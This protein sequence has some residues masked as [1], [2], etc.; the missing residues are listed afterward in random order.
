MSEAERTNLFRRNR[1]AFRLHHPKIWAELERIEKPVSRA[2]IENDLVVN[3][4]LGEIRLYPDPAPAWTVRQLDDYFANPDR[5]VFENPFHCNLS[6]VSVEV[7]RDIGDYL[8]EH[9]RSKPASFPVV[10]VG[11]AFI[12]GVG[13][14]LHVADL[15]RRKVARNLILIEP[16]PEF[17]LHSM[18]AVDWSRIFTAAR[19][20]GMAIDFLLGKDPGATI[21]GI[22]VLFSRRGTTFL[23]GSYAYRH[24]HSWV[25]Q[26]ARAQLNE[27]IKVFYFSS[28]FFEDEILMMQNTYG[29]LR[30]RAFHVVD[31]RPRIARR[32]PAFVIGSGSSLDRDLPYIKKW[33]DRA[34]VCS[35]GTSL[36]ILLKNGI[37]PD[38]H[39]ENENTLPLVK[40]L[41]NFRETYGLDGIRLVCTTTLRPEAS[42]LFDR[43]WF[44]YRAPLSSSVVLSGGIEPLPNADPLVSNAGCAAL[45]YLGFQDIYLFGVDC[46]RHFEGEHHSR[47]AVYYQ[48]GYDINPHNRPDAGFE[49]VVPGNFGGKVVTSW[50][51]DLSRRSITAL[52]K[53]RDVSVTNCSDGARIEGTRPKVA[54][55]LNFTYPPNEQEAVLTDIEKSLPFFKPGEMLDKTDLQ[56]HADACDVFE[57]SFNEVIDK[58]IEEDSGF[59]EFEQRLEA[60]WYGDWSKHKGVLRIIGGSYASMVRLGAFAGTR[61]RSQKA[62]MAFFHFFLERYRQSCLWMAAETRTL[63]QE[64]AERR[65]EI[66]DVGKIP[67]PAEPPAC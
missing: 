33:R 35:C 31:R 20:Q 40:N 11:Y 44:Y 32:M 62:R 52:L 55:A 64:M 13:L 57:E 46:G 30:E 2:V 24:Y 14:G 42:G 65:P 45:A 3:I 61:L 19:K 47:D 66:S 48:D 54:G 25:L 60:F 16:I 59:W 22:E 8:A 29:N 41:Q 7:L 9:K 6:P 15:V 18:Q 23:D 26:E 1:N 4:D 50:S 12:F 5:L 67:E 53:K 38:L 37:R 51:L 63:L 56:A 58:A 28:G 36:G 10:D 21:D 49:R 34:I 17:L 43:R 27:K 39:V